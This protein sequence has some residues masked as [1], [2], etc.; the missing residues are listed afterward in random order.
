MAVITPSASGAAL[1]HQNA[2]GG[3]DTFANSGVERVHVVNGGG[4]S[5]TVTLVRTQACNQGVVHAGAA[6][7]ASDQVSVPA[8]EDRLL[9]A[10][11]PNIYG[12]TVGITYS[13]VTSV[14]VGVIGR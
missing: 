13:A 5:I 8:G 14:T 1:T 4:S 11:D 2:A 9:R 7:I 3:G 12:S 10:V 6:A